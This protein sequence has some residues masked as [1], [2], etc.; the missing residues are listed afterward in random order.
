MILH[1]T[2]GDAAGDLLAHAAPPG[3]ILAWRDVLY[4]GPRV[5]GWPDDNALAARAQFLV[6]LTGGA[7]RQDAVRDTLRRQYD[8]LASAAQREAV[9]LWFD[10]CLFDLAMLVHVLHCLSQVPGANAELLVV[11]AFP[12]LEP[13]HG[14][15]Q[16]TAAQLASC[17]DRRRP[18]T[19]ADYHYAR[20]VDDAFAKP[21]PARLE[22][23]A[24]PDLAP[25]LP[26]VPAAIRR[27]LAEQPAAPGQ[28]T[29]LE[30]LALHAVRAGHTAPGA[31]LREVAAADTPPQY[32]GDT[33]L[34]AKLN[35]LADRHLVWIDGPQPRLPQW[36]AADELPRYRVTPTA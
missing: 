19:P 13:Y 5:P 1:L 23:L 30:D 8:T 32:W 17:Y 36:D 2:S 24:A 18:V 20:Q 14:L 29:R 4:E 11:D 21:D 12:G 31:I 16:L 15:G 35:A 3:D 34:W 33:T 22:A 25:P 26:W 27:W 28:L 7:L 10:A 9:V 6:S